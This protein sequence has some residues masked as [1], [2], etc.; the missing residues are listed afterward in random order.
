MLSGGR[1]VLVYL[2][3][4]MIK[5]YI[6]QLAPCAGIVWLRPMH[7]VMRQDVA[8]RSSFCQAEALRPCRRKDGGQI[9]Q[10]S[11][12]LRIYISHGPLCM[13]ICG[14]DGRGFLRSIEWPTFL[15][16]PENTQLAARNCQSSCQSQSL[17]AR[18]TAT[19]HATR[20]QHLFAG[21]WSQDS[22]AP[23]EA[24]GLKAGRVVQVGRSSPVT[25]RHR[26]Q[27]PRREDRGYRVLVRGEQR[28]V[29]KGKTI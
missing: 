1:G 17:S 15:C 4:L 5:G 24:R 10:P 22:A 7:P 14:F 29:K 23:K 16:G 9:S 12:P 2:K 25:K 3:A 13:I 26:G 28:V 11:R 6:L 18:Y 19:R 27:G 20:A 8:A 21:W